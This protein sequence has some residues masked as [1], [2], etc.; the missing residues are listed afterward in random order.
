MPAL[1]FMVVAL[2][3]LRASARRGASLD[4]AAHGQLLQQDFISQQLREAQKT[5]RLCARLSHSIKAHHTKGRR[6]RASILQRT[7]KEGKYS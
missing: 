6:R 1:P 3:R 2:Q 7:E 4:R 5:S